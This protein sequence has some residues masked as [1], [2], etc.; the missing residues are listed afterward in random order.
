MNV[1]IARWQL[2]LQAYDFKVE[3]RKGEENIADFISRNCAQP[4]QQDTDSI[5]ATKFVKAIVSYSIPKSMT[6]KEIREESEKDIAI[7]AVQNALLTGKWHDNPLV[8]R[9]KSIQTE[10]SNVDGILLRDNRI[11]LPETPRKKAVN[12]AHEGHLDVSLLCCDF[13]FCFEGSLEITQ[14]FKWF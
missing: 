3:Y 11:V 1:R 10:L 7:V 12:I 13:V 2:K 5:R 6:L 9:Y 4:V 8:S 14:K